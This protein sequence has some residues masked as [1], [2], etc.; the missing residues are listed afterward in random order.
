MW[1]SKEGHLGKRYSKNSS[2]K[3]ELDV[4]QEPQE[5]WYDW[6]GATSGE[7]E[8]LR[9]AGWGQILS[10]FADCDRFLFWVY[11]E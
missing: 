1:R 6:S 3:L 10:G 5:G 2:L 4:L 7:M 9:K 8:M 11:W